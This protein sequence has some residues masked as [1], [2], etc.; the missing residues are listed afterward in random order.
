VVLSSGAAEHTAIA[1][2]RA[3]GHMLLDRSRS[4]A[5]GLQGNDD[6]RAGPWLSGDGDPAVLVLHAYVDNQVVSFIANNETAISA[7]V[8]PTLQA[9]N[10]VSRGR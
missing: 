3:Q 10:Q 5:A 1:F 2:D 4:G 6:V 9:S 8:D 7:W